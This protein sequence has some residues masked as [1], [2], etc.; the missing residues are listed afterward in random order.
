MTMILKYYTYG[1]QQNWCGQQ[2]NNGFM[3]N[4]NS[5]KLLKKRNS[6]I[7]SNCNVHKIRVKFRSTCSNVKNIKS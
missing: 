2:W 1:C 4:H 6:Q 3:N 5:G 7:S